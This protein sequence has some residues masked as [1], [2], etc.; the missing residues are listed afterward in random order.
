MLNTAHLVE[1]T[2]SEA[3]IPCAHHLHD[4]SAQ[5]LLSTL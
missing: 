4:A 3:C 5:C 2:K 1:A